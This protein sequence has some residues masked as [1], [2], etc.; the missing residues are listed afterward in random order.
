[1]PSGGSPPSRYSVS[2][3]TISRST[4]ARIAVS[5]GQ[6]R[7]SRARDS[8]TSRAATPPAPAR[9]AREPPPPAAGRPGSPRVRGAAPPASLD[10]GQQ[11]AALDGRALGDRQGLD[12]PGPVGG[13]LVFPLHRPDDGEQPG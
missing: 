6:S 9:G 8:V 12:R 4:P 7:P 1:M 3:R 2:S 5:G 13:G 10:D 11:V